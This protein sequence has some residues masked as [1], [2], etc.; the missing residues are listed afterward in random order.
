MEARNHRQDIVAATN[1][2]DQLNVVIR[3]EGDMSDPELTGLSPKV[4]VFA[5]AAW[6]LIHERRLEERW[7]ESLH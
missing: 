1:G 5:G 2:C 7:Y 4:K 6:A 3:A